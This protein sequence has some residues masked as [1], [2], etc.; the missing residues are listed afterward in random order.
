M[1]GYGPTRTTAKQPRGTC[2]DSRLPWARRGHPV[3]S[4]VTLETH[5]AVAVRVVALRPVQN[6]HQRKAEPSTGGCMRWSKS[7]RSWNSA[8]QGSDLEEALAAQSAIGDDQLERQG[9]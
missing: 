5:I 2:Q 3:R 6:L 9:R 1:P 7:R 8:N 4:G